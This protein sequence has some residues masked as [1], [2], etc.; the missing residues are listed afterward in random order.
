MLQ[1]LIN[2]TAIWLISLVLFD[3]FFRRESY[4][5]YNRAYLLITF[6]S[7]IMIPSLPAVASDHTAHTNTFAT[8]VDELITAKQ[9]FVTNV[10]PAAHSSFSWG[11][12][13]LCIYIAGLIVTTILLL[14]DIC[15]VI[16][17]Y[18]RGQKTADGAFTIIETG[19]EHS[20][21][22]LLNYVFVS[23][24]K[25]YNDVEWD[26]VMAHEQKHGI[27]LHFIDL[28]LMQ[29]SRVVFWFHPLIYLYQQRLTMV[30]EYQA[31]NVKNIKPQPYG[32]FLIEQSLLQHAPA[33][34]HSFNR[35]PIKN[36]VIMLTKN[37]AQRSLMAKIKPLLLLPVMAFSIVCCTRNSYPDTKV[38][39]GNK[40]TYK[41][42]VFTLSESEP[43]T[44]T[45]TGT[46]NKPSGPMTVKRDPYPVSMN[47]EKIYSSQDVSS[48][49]YFKGD[50]GAYW[51][52]NIKSA[53]PSLPD[54]DYYL[55]VK[56]IVVDKNGTIV[57]YDVNGLM[58]YIDDA[59]SFTGQK[60]VIISDAP[61]I[62]AI[63]KLIDNM[64]KFEPANNSGTPVASVSGSTLL[65]PTQKISIHEGQVN[66]VSR[67]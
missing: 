47:N 3:V 6:I 58:Y 50:I 2:A 38:K 62:S 43:M 67:D 65:M 25:Y 52:A 40:V 15:K 46:G 57:Y 66:I 14:A 61:V 7:G 26:I 35:S 27:S 10:Q 1:Y 34:T 37:N 56:N 33:I 41:G 16:R 4:H 48:K 36:R 45:L 30:H 42:N 20:P 59:K 64:P 51:A 60:Q 21:F 28:L 17:L 32:K 12:L 44:V 55:F 54:R 23:H 9:R 19:K 11:T 8:Q 63:S 53:L 18:S 22:S 39:D 31:D 29:L 5:G 13:L 49:P 24:R